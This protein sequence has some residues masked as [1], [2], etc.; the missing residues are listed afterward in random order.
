MDEASVFKLK[1][2]LEKAMGI[3]FPVNAPKAPWKGGFMECLMAQIKRLMKQAIPKYP[4]MT[5][6]CC[7][8]LNC[9]LLVL[10]P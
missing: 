4:K 2:T 8:E 1:L 9:Q 6:T 3:Q 7:G 10:L 5:T